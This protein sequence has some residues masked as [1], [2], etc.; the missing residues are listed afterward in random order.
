MLQTH[1]NTFRQNEHEGV[2]LLKQAKISKAEK[3]EK[4]FCYR[5][6]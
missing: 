4:G 1:Q 2:L 3:K 6:I 5:I